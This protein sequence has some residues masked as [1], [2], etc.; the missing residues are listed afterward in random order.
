MSERAI[1]LADQID[2]YYS[3]EKDLKLDSR[4]LY[5]LLRGTD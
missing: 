5:I 1:K 3:K 4:I 2:Y